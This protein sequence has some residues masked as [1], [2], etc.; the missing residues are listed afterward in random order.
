[1][2]KRCKKVLVSW[3]KVTHNQLLQ[4]CSLCRIL[5]QAVREETG[6]V[7]FNTT[8]WHNVLFSD[9]HLQLQLILVNIGT[10]KIVQRFLIHTIC[11]QSLEI[12]GQISRGALV[13]A[14]NQKVQSALNLSNCRQ[15]HIHNVHYRV[16]SCRVRI[17]SVNLTLE[18]HGYKSQQ[19][20]VV[21]KLTSLT[22]QSSS[23]NIAIGG[24]LSGPYARRRIRNV[25]FCHQSLCTQHLSLKATNRCHFMTILH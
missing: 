16:C 11:S 21:G 20:V 17:K 14:E 19:V 18:F 4:V 24:L 22:M 8:R 1:M 10:E 25:S 12:R 13:E 6:V 7:H 9:A 5:Y 3:L 15:M 23:S 2:V